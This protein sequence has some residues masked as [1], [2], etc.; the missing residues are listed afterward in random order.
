MCYWISGTNDVSVS[1]ADEVE[2]SADP[3]SVETS[4]VVDASAE[5]VDSVKVADGAAPGGIV[6]FAVADGP[7]SIVELELYAAMQ[8]YCPYCTI[9][10]R[11]SVY[12]AMSS[13]VRW[14]ASHYV[15]CTRLRSTTGGI[16][17]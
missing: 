11:S 15:R 14:I 6:V 2:A 17:L 10:S 8:I 3:P 4:A 7:A 5:S 13:G 16:P 9:V 12:S 1:D